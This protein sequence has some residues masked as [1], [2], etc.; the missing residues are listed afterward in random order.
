VSFQTPDPARY[1]DIVAAFA[2]AAFSQDYFKEI[3]RKYKLYPE[4][5]MRHPMEDV[6]HQ[7]KEATRITVSRVGELQLS[8]AYPDPALAQRVTRDMADRLVESN[9]RR[10]QLLTQ[11][12]RVVIVQPPSPGV[13]EAPNRRAIALA[14]VIGGILVGII[15]TWVTWRRRVIV[16]S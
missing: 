12:L 14:G 9:I 4:Q 15:A 8:F 7:A 10:P 2:H 5:R 6:I 11:A 13:R 16:S 3:I 1:P